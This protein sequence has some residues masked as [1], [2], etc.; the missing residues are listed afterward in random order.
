MTK[1]TALATATAF[2]HRLRYYPP[3]VCL[4]NS[5]N[6]PAPGYDT[7]T[8]L[9]TRGW[10]LLALGERA[11]SAAYRVHA[12]DALPRTAMGAIVAVAV[13]VRLRRAVPEHAET[14]RHRRKRLS[15]RGSKRVAH[16]LTR[17]HNHSNQEAMVVIVFRSRLREGVDEQELARLGER[18]YEIASSMPG[19]ISYKDFTAADGEN[20]AIVEFDS[21]ETLTAWREHPEHQAAQQRGRDEFFAEYHI[22]VCTPQRNYA[23]E[24]EP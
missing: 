21:P 22:Q 17:Q 1:G 3:E 16:D 10:P 8:P 11:I 20:V 15:S 24:R 7:P 13:S 23:F 12:I 14:E 6:R 4:S 9:F 5:P 18:M 19:F 2:G